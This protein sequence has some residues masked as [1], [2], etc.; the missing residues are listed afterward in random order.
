MHILLIEELEE[1]IADTRGVLVGDV[2]VGG[3][4]EGATSIVSSAAKQ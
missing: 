1:E 4:D 3:A 2:L